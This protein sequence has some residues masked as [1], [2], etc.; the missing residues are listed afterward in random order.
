MSNL[1]A[2]GLYI[3]TKREA[4]GSGGFLVAEVHVNHPNAAE[5]AK[6][7]AAAEEMLDVLQRLVRFNNMVRFPGAKKANVEL[8]AESLLMELT[9]ESL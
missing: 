6:K 5:T 9:G 7:F 8:D 2:C 4:D 1:E 3:R